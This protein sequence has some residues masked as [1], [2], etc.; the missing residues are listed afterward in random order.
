MQ[1]SFMRILAKYQFGLIV[2]LYL[3]GL[4]FIYPFGVNA[5]N[6]DS[7]QYYFWIKDIYTHHGGYFSWT[8]A[9]GYNQLSIIHIFSY[10]IGWVTYQS[11][12]RFF[13]VVNFTELVLLLFASLLFIRF[14]RA[15]VPLDRNLEVAA[16][17]SELCCKET[18]CFLREI[19]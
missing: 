3:C 11:P 15:S 8:T 13:T 9:A 4:G 5:F 2:V 14:N 19:E 10:L 18:S 17:C 1:M 7:N 12:I 16:L 6:G